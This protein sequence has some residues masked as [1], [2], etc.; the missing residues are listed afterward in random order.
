MG[1]CA[2]W[3]AKEE[4]FVV[5]PSSQGLPLFLRKSKRPRMARICERGALEATEEDLPVVAPRGF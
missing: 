1:A 3:M 2:R 5:T 4:H